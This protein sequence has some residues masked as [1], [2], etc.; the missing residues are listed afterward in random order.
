MKLVELYN[1][2]GNISLQG[3]FSE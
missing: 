3:R 2:S 1:I